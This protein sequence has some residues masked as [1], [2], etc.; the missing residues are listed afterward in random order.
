MKRAK[1]VTCESVAS[2]IKELGEVPDLVDTQEDL[3][4]SRHE[5]VTTCFNSWLQRI[6]GLEQLTESQKTSLSANVKD[7]PWSNEQRKELART[8][9]AVGTEIQ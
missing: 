3:G 9:L 4:L 7:G 6:H 1:R 2:M 5:V 8:I